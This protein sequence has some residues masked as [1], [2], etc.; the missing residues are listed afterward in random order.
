MFHRTPLIAESRRPFSHLR[1]SA[2]SSQCASGAAAMSNRLVFMSQSKDSVMRKFQVK[3]ARLLLQM[4]FC[5]CDVF[6]RSFSFQFQ[7]A[8]CTKRLSYVGV[9]CSCVSPSTDR[10]MRND[11]S[12]QLFEFVKSPACKYSLPS[13][14]NAG[15]IS[16]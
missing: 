6:S 8:K 10:V 14:S 4:F 13:A 11:S 16:G 9:P 12:K 1:C 7:L 5:L 15:A 2:G 3:H